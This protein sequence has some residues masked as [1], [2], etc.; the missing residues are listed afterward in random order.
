MKKIYFIAILFLIMSCQTHIE[1]KREPQKKQTQ[2]VSVKT[3][4]KHND[5]TQKYGLIF[6]KPEHWKTNFEDNK[7]VNLKGEIMVLETDYSNTENNSKI[8]LKLHPNSDIAKQIYNSKLE[9]IKHGAKFVN[10]G[11]KQGIEV[12]ETIH[13]DGKGHPINPPVT[14]KIISILTSQGEVDIVFDITKN[15]ALREYQN[16]LSQLKVN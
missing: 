7:S 9:K 14:R 11:N 13:Y 1:N 6:V 12:T 3:N 8:R 16:F 5:F 10:F 4:K 15:Q 2:T